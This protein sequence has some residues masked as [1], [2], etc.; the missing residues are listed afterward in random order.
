MNKLLQSNCHLISEL[1][2]LTLFPHFPPDLDVG[3]ASV[4]VANFPI[5]FSKKKTERGK[6]PGHRVTPVFCDY[7]QAT[8]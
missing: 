2:Q 8:I 5:P 6:L 7:V 4:P 1:H 3:G